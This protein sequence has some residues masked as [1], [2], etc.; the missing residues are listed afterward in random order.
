[1]KIEINLLT[2]L[3]N[4]CL[5]FLN[6]S[7]YQ[8]DALGEALSQ[9]RSKRRKGRIETFVKDIRLYQHINS[10]TNLG[11]KDALEKFFKE[12]AQVFI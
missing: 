3:N 10:V 11:V 6:I 7:Y 5:L 9:Y 1:M 8:D 12:Y 2:H 4:Y